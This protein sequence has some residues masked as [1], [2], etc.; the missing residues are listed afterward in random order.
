MKFVYSDKVVLV[1]VANNIPMI[2][3][4]SQIPMETAAVRSLQ[5]ELKIHPVFCELLVQRGIRNFQ[6]AKAFFRPRLEELHDPFLMKDM[7]RALSR[8]NQAMEK[9]EGILLYGDYDVDGTCC[10]ALSYSFFSKLYPKLDYYIPDRYK[11]GYGISEPG[12]DYA[13]QKGISLIIAMDCGIRAVG[14]V[15]EAKKRGIDFIICDH[16]LPGEEIPGAVAVL[17]PKRP[18]CA[19]PYKEL[20]G[21]GVVFK[22][23]QAYCRQHHLGWD[24]WKGLLDYLVLSIACDIV[25]LTGENR[26]LAHFGLLQLNQ[27]QRMGLSVLIRKSGRSGPL[28]IS[29]LV[30]GLGPLLNAAGRMAD[31]QQ[32]VR[33]MLSQS[34]S[35]AREFADQLVLHNLR[36]KS[37]EQAIVDQAKGQILADPAW[38]Q[39]KT[40][41]LSSPDWHKGVIGIAASRM[42]DQ[43]SRPSII[44]T[45]VNG[46]LVGSARSV[47]GFNIYRALLACSDHLENFGGHAHAAG[48]S[49]SPEKLPAFR[50]QFEKVVAGSIAESALIPEIKISGEL[51]LTAIDEKFWNILKQFAPFGPQNRNPVFVCREVWDTGHSRLLKGNHLKLSLKQKNSEAFAGIGFGLGDAWRTMQNRSFDI[52]YNLQENHWQGRTNLQLNVKDIKFAEE[53]T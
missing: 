52:C 33:L 37:L 36:R 35:Q 14:L 1:S 30:F 18:D 46:K 7:D 11:E 3:L 44:F 34:E 40:I 32:A 19:Y 26:I 53:G 12:I 24:H 5:S 47:K 6:Q 38:A 45:E 21:C 4:W 31:A 16:H 10:I 15:R 51:P 49:M 13:E 8:L 28:S 50:A 23:I 2:K 48:L 27:T 25:P 39:N 17:D 20:S 9:G 43:F 29:D 22:L 41:V 42:V